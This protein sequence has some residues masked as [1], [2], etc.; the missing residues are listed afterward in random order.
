MIIIFIVTCQKDVPSPACAGLASAATCQALVFLG[1]IFANLD[2]IPGYSFL[3][4]FLF[5]LSEHIA[6]FKYG[7]V[8]TGN[9]KFWKWFSEKK[10]YCVAFVTCT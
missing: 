9:W 4:N 1:V 5:F 3:I 6:I 2:D 7:G 8:L 10:I